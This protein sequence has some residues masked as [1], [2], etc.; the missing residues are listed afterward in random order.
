MLL[1]KITKKDKEIRRLVN[2]FYRLR[3]ATWEAPIVPIE[4]P[5]KNGYVKFFTLRD[6]YTRRVDVHDFKRIL[7][8]INNTVFSRN[9]DFKDKKG[10][11]HS[12]NLSIIPEKQWQSFDWPEHYKKHFVFG[13]HTYYYGWGGKGTIYGYKFWREYCFTEKIEPH[14]VTHQRVVLPEIESRLSEIRAKFSNEQLWERYRSMKGH[15]RFSMDYFLEK[16]HILDSIG[17][18]ELEKFDVTKGDYI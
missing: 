2:E 5:Y 17:T 18:K 7:S 4:K 10:V 12:P 11:I 16:Q 15:K 3:K 8:R 14:F 9:K 6:D 13:H 1:D